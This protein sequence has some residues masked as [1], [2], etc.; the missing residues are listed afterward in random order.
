MIAGH[1][2]IFWRAPTIITHLLL[3]VIS[4]MIALVFLRF[5][6]WTIWILL[7]LL[8]HVITLADALFCTSPPLL[9]MTT[10]FSGI[11][12]NLIVTNTEKRYLHGRILSNMRSFM[13]AHGNL[14]LSW[15]LAFPD[16]VY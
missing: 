13:T 15:W 5:A 3:I 9:C 10:V 14:L 16:G 7:I 12:V 2:A 8:Y 1:I 4:V 6:D 11:S